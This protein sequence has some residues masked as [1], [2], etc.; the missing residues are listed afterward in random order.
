MYII[1]FIKNVINYLRNL[2]NPF[3][4]VAIEVTIRNF[5]TVF[6]ICGYIY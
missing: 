5:V 1:D 4:P 6:R 2:R 3:L